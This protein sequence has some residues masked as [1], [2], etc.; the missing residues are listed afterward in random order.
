MASGPLPALRLAVGTACM[1]QQREQHHA[2]QQVQ[3]DDRRE[4]LHRHRERAERALQA[5]PARA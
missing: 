4:Q 5:H 1:H 3:G 2:A